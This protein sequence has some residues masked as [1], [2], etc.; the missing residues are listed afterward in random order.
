MAKIVDEQ[1][2]VH[3]NG[4]LFLRLLSYMK[5]YV[6]QIFIIACLI[7]ITTGLDLQRPIIIGDAIDLYIEAYYEP[8]AIVEQNSDTTYFDGQYLIKGQEG[9]SYAQMLYDGKNYYFYTNLTPSQSKQLYDIS[10]E[11][12]TNT[13]FTIDGEV[14]EGRRLTNEE[15]QILRQ[16]DY[17]GI[18]KLG[19]LYM[20][21]LMLSAYFTYHQMMMLQRMGQK[22]IFTIRQECFRHVH[23]LPLRYFDTRPVGRIVTRITNDV[24]SLHQMY[25][26]ILSRMVRNVVKIIGLT[27]VMLWMNTKLALCAFTFIPLIIVITLTYKTLSRRAHRHIRT[28]VSKLNTFLSENLSGMKMIQIFAKEDKKYKEFKQNSATLYK[29]HFNQIKVQ[30]FIQPWIYLVAQCALA[31]VIYEGA[32]DVLGSTMSIGSLYIFINYISNFYEP[33]QELAEQVS[34]LQNA[35]ASSEKIF[36]LL[37]ETNDIIEKEQPIHLENPRGHIEFKNVWFAYEGEDYVLKDISFTIE[38]GKKVA[39]V[40]ATGAGK[41]SILNLIGRYYDIQKG[42]ILIDGINIKDLSIQ[43]IREA[44]GQVQQDVFLFTGDIAS[45]ITLGNPNISIEDV[46]KAATHVNASHFIEQFEECY[47]HP[48]SERGSTLSAGQRQL[49]SFARTIAYNPKILVLD[50]ATSNIDTESELL[51]T[52]ALEKL[53]DG[54]TTIMVAHRLSTIQHADTIM[55]MDHGEIKERG[56][57]QEL[58]AKDGIYKKLYELQ[59]A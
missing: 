52:D 25:A 14:L 58:L 16:S 17:N 33:V 1:Q 56:N 20:G 8:Y 9:N 59:L 18:V 31:L 28:N 50:E 35:L 12:V 39:F 34:N 49:I 13:T 5:P 48:V 26:G 23:S 55:V 40:G 46:K 54:R 47:H 2:D 24:E 21:V 45:N 37:D 41:S 22:I 53:M 11:E 6:K 42:E 36:T 7:L 57:H 27:G 19:F 4:N 3:Y 51:I 15:C 30:S 44:I 38:P 10:Q 32:K 29:S 43:S